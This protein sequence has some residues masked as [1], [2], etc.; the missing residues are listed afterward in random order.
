MLVLSRLDLTTCRD[1]AVGSPFLRDSSPPRTKNRLI[2]IPPQRLRLAQR[3]FKLKPRRRTE[4]QVQQS[5]PDSI[6]I[7]PLPFIASY[8]PLLGSMRS[9]RLKRAESARKARG[10]ARRGSP[11]RWFYRRR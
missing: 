2:A 11:L 10:M 9:R 5:R 1:F 4:L 6:G 3:R 7:Q 8:T